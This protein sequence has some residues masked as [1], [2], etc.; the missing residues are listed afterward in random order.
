MH[1]AS[2]PLPP[3]P[4]TPPYPTTPAALLATVVTVLPWIPAGGFF[5]SL[6]NAFGL[7]SLLGLTLD[8]GGSLAMGT[9]GLECDPHF[10][11]PFLLQR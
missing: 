7:Y 11:H 2:F 3:L 5:Y 6:A 1:P 8:V 4:P 9:V 10:D